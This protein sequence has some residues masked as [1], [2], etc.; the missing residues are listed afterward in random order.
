VSFSINTNVTSLQA[1]SN[2]RASGD[3]QAKTINRVTSGLRIVSSGDDAAGLAIA[4]GFRSDQSVL[5][6]GIRNANDGLSTLQ[7]IDGGMNNI[8]MLLDRARTLAT[9]SA[10]GTFAGSRDVL[11]SEFQNVLTEIDRQSTAIGMNTGGQFAKTM[12]VFIGGGK[13]ASGVAGNIISNGSVSVDLSK[14]SVDNQ[15]LGMKGFTAVNA[16]TYNLASGATSVAAI[17]ADANNLASVG[18]AT[19]YSLSGPGF[20]AVSVTLNVN[21][22]LVT[23]TTSLVAAAN[24]AIQS[25]VATSNS[26]FK[27]ANIV[28]QITTSATGAQQ[29]QFSSSNTA[30]EVTGTTKTANAL[31]GNFVGLTAE[32]AAVGAVGTSF[33][34]G[35]TQQIT[36]AFVSL[37]TAQAEKEVLSFTALDS[38]GEPRSVAVPL[39]TAVASADMTAAQ[40]AAAINAALEATD[41][42]ALKSIV[43]VAD[44][45]GTN[46]TFASSSSTK[47]NV[48]FGPT[49]GT[50]VIAE[51]FNSSVNTIVT[52]S[53][54]GT[55]GNADISNQASA[56]SAVG[57]LAQA[58]TT[59]GAAQANVGKSE[60]EF[61]YAM[62]LAQS[63]STNLAAAES[64][65]RDADLA[66]EAANLTKAQILIQAGTA[67][68]AQA[69]S[70]PQAILS[71]LK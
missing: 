68:L 4:N 39:D 30:F 51:G 43:A 69:N 8:S 48:S 37:L 14:S 52:S 47:F 46:I 32:G 17:L 40:A 3:F 11:N 45:A 24:N 60:N 67:A 61:N 26:A 53:V 29:L 70:A 62:N 28:A 6:Q 59:L 25:A 20:S 12:S 36:S 42:P 65:I 63:Q 23:D 31:M 7:T 27:A 13:D 1:Q 58:V 19:T 15:S 50:G 41:D 57:A 16:N 34:A 55:G 38:N 2:L 9:Q 10:S 54:V 22:S 71:L 18:G 33:V 44:A 66:S 5:T 49:T 21:T 56:S 64:R 35:G